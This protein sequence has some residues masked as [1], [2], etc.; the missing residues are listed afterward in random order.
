MMDWKENRDSERRF[1]C[2]ELENL[3]G[4]EPYSGENEDFRAAWLTWGQVLDSACAKSPRQEVSFKPAPI[5]SW[6]EKRSEKTRRLGYWK[7]LCGGALVFLAIFCL[8]VR[9]SRE[10]TSVVTGNVPFSDLEWDDLEE[11]L[12]I[13]EEDME[14][15]TEDFS[16]LDTEIALVS[17]SLDSFS[18][19]TESG[20]F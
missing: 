13:L 15:M 14:E 7:S 3:T 8:S 5:S 20:L 4:K 10:P 2:E 11:D 17:Y 16:P 12:E 18:E 1:T 19:E 6:E 9:Q